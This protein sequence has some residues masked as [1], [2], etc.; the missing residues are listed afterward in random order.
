[1]LLRRIDIRVSFMGV[2]LMII[3]TIVVVTVMG[4]LLWTVKEFM[5]GKH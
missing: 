3:E 4:F 5:G 2:L 1:M